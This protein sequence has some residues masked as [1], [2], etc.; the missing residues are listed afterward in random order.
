MT[1]SS[2]VM[3]SVTKQGVLGTDCSPDYAST[4]E[5]SRAIGKKEGY[6]F[7][8]GTESYATSKGGEKNA[9]FTSDADMGLQKNMG[10]S[11]KY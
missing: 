11:G 9:N 1:M 4:S 10:K 6:S 8:S 5:S 7:G 3:P 2:K